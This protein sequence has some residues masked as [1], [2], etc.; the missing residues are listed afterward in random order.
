VFEN[1]GLVLCYVILKKPKPYTGLVLCFNILKKPKPYTC[2]V[3]C[4]LNPTLASSSVSID[5]NP[6]PYIHLKP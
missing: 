6:K 5:L 4:Y 1:T 2:L 3:L